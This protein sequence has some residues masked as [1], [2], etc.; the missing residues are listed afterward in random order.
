MSCKGDRA[1]WIGLFG[2]EMQLFCGD[3]GSFSET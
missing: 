2:G 1:V 3:K